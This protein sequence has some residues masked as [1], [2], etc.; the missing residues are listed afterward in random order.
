MI[1][2]YSFG[3]N[4]IILAKK[5]FVAYI[6]PIAIWFIVWLIA[7]SISIILSIVGIIIGVGIIRYIR[8]YTLFVDDVG[9]WIFQGISPWNRGINGIKW[10]DFE[11]AEYYLDP[12]S[13]LLKSYNIHIKNRYKE[14]P[15][16]I[17]KD[18]YNGDI[19]VSQINAM[20]M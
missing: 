20:S 16:F 13:W 9:I 4:P 6:K 15:A 7:S 17:L 18:M 12:L 2:Q 8:S 14:D 1:A 5:S 19:A 10:C 11:K 3:N